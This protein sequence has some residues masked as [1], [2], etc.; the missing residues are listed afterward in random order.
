MDS[1][2]PY[3]SLSGSGGRSSRK[4][5][6]DTSAMQP[7]LSVA[8]LDYKRSKKKRG[9]KKPKNVCT[10]RSTAYVE[11]SARSGTRPKLRPKGVSP[12][13]KSQLD[14]GLRAAGRQGGFR[15]VQ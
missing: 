8:S 14:I 2:T 15:A 4:R 7:I 3:L 13:P 1:N 6:R 12:E 9:E 5:E 10:L 11:M